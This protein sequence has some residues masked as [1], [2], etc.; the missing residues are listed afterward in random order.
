MLKKTVETLRLETLLL[1]AIGVAVLIRVC[2]VGVRELWYDEALSLLLSTGQKTSYLTPPNHPVALADYTQLLGLPP[3]SNLTA[4]L[5]LLKPLLQ[6]IVGQEPHPPLFFLA[7]YVWLFVT[8]TAEGSLRSLNLLLSLVAMVAAF[9]MGRALLG[10]RAGLLM[11]ALLGLNPFFWFHSLN[12]RMYAPTVMW[13][14]LSGWATL[15]L[16]DPCD[17]LP[18]R[19]R[20]LWAIVLTAAI[21]GGLMTFYLYALWLMAL[22]V[23]AL[24]TL[25]P[26]RPWLIRCRRGWWQYG[27]CLAIGIV[28][29]SPWYAWGLPQQLRNADLDRFAS[30]PTL[31]NGILQHVKGIL[32]V[33]GIQLG[34]GDWVTSLP[35][36]MPIVVGLVLGL[37][38]AG[39]VV[40][41][42]Y[43]GQLQLASIAL[44]LGVLPLLL[45]LGMDLVSGRATLAWG[46]GRSVIFILPGLLLLATVWMMQLP[47]KWQRSVIAFC[48]LVYLVIDLGDMAG[49]ERQVFR[50]VSQEIQTAP[51]PTLLVMNSEA[52]GHVCRLAYY[53][54]S[55]A[56]VDLLAVSPAELPGTLKTVLSASATTP[57]ARVLWLEA[58][59][60]LWNQPETAAETNQIRQSVTSTL[61]KNYAPTAQQEL[62][63]TMSLDRF[64]LTAYERL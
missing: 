36:F 54:P 38:L 57:Y 17:R 51:E 43:K 16:Y 20:W 11:A 35:A 1:G 60:P 28:I 5:H 3:L 29:V 39:M 55:E 2:Y 37:L 47:P 8:G 4:S 52:W 33:I 14:A 41:L 30:S 59:D 64:S 19:Q 56:S 27:L 63:G 24:I 32:E 48:L 7:Q 50:Q 31:L 26:Q 18:R 34:L 6:G 62:T 61:A 21:V 9:G 10:Y 58:H 22:G 45:A 40:Q 25:D 44:I 13:V 53:V 12:M 15:A 42:F 46:Y 23:L 49:R